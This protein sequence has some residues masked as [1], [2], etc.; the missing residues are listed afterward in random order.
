MIVKRLIK[1]IK[2]IST[3]MFEELPFVINSVLLSGGF[4]SFWHRVVNNTNTF[5]N[6]FFDICWLSVIFLL[7]ACITVNAVKKSLVRGLLYL[8]PLT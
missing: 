4:M 2:A 5:T 6:F 1:I 3:P 8:I 7:L